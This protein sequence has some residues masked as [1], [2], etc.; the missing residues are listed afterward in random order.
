MADAVQDALRTILLADAPVLAVVSTKIW[1]MIAPQG[2]AMPYIVYSR[3]GTD[4][5]EVLAGSAGLARATFQIDC[6]SD[7]FDT[8]RDLA[9]KV[10][11]ALQGVQGTHASVVIDGINM[12]SEVDDYEEP[13][14]KNEPGTYGVKMDFGIWFVESTS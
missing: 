10:R 9:N 6:W 1:P 2:S 13:E 4:H 14:N 11:I 8:V 5:I 3:I 12:T 7:S